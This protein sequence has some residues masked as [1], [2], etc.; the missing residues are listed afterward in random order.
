MGQDETGVDTL[1]D[2]PNRL[3]RNSG[4]EHLLAFASGP[5][6]QVIHPPVNPGRFSL[7]YLFPFIPRRQS[8]WLSSRGQGRASVRSGPINGAGMWAVVFSDL[9]SWELRIH[10]CGLHVKITCGEPRRLTSRRS[11]A[12]QGSIPTE[13]EARIGPLPAYATSRSLAAPRL[14]Y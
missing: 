8:R 13:F 9:R 6:S 12:F 1:E 14:Q 3:S 7:A 2:H 4:E 5:S 11:C 10:T